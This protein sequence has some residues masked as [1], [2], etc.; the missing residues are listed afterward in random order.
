MPRSPDEKARLRM[1]GTE[2]K[3]SGR[4]E[5]KKKKNKE[6]KKRETTILVN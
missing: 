1:S 2:K 3:G 6:K 4:R 5:R